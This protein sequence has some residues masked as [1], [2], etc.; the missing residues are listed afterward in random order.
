MDEKGFTLLESLTVLMISSL[1]MVILF[2]GLPPIYEKKAVQNF[3]SQ[4][5]EDLLYAQQ[6]AL[7]QNTKVKVQFDFDHFKYVILPADKR[8]DPYLTRTYDRKI[9]IKKST[10]KRQLTYSPNGAPNQGGKMVIETGD[11]Y[12]ELTIYLG[13][14]KINV[15][16]K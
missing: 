4:L 9:S 6:T 3:V 12:F 8:S 13:S 5:E 16:T 7:A 11:A 14:G 10:L 15:Q 1:M 2:A